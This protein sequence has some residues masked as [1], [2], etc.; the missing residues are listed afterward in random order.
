LKAGKTELQP[1]AD[2]IAE[3]A[4]TELPSLKK[5]VQDSGAPAIL[6]MDD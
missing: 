3:I 5:A 1:I 6:E 2:R 4:E